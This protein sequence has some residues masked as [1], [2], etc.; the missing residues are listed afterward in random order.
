MPLLAC[1]FALFLAAPSAAAEDGKAPSVIYVHSLV[2]MRSL[3]P[4]DKLDGYEAFNLAVTRPARAPFFRVKE[5]HEHFGSGEG[6]LNYGDA[7]AEWEERARDGDPAAMSNLGVLYDLGLG[8]APNA[9]RAVELYNAAANR[10][11][12]TAQNNL[13]I[14]YAQGRG[15]ERD[16]TQAIRWL[17]AAGKNGLMLADNNLGVL[18]LITGDERSG[19]VWLS[20][21]VARGGAGFGGAARNL[22]RLY[23]AKADDPGFDEWFWNTVVAGLTGWPPV[24]DGPVEAYNWFDRGAERGFPAARRKRALAEAAGRASMERWAASFFSASE[25]ELEEEQK[26]VAKVD[27]LLCSSLRRNNFVHL[28]KLLKRS[29]QRFL[30]REMRLERAYGYLRCD[31]IEAENIDLIRLLVEDPLGTD[32]VAQE[33]IDYFVEEVKNGEF[34]L[35]RIVMCKDDFGQYGC[36]N[37]LEHAEKNLKEAT[38]RPY[39]T[40]ALTN[41]KR[42]LHDRLD[43]GHLKYNRNFC[44]AFLGEPDHCG[45]S[46]GK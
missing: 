4:A 37:V 33:L 18:Y 15:V 39:R 5:E 35:G 41:F 3:V 43:E 10:G 24:P 38:G 23:D 29:S 7:I 42:L 30:G 11:S 12:A 32:K 21:A 1:V 28:Q 26:F 9:A 20:R 14:A 46:S 45:D 19:T 2:V 34:L 13:G 40:K 22:A 16:E 27:R 6:R 31:H 36:L 44:R 25:K 17:S 8:V